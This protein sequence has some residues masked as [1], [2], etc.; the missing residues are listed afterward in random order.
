[1][2]EKWKKALKHLGINENL[3]SRREDLYTLEP[4]QTNNISNVK[5]GLFLKH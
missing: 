4:F 1:M 2:N 5:E 3:L